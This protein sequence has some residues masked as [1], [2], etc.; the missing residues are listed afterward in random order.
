[1]SHLQKLAER[2]KY[3]ARSTRQRLQIDLS[4]TGRR[5]GRCQLERGMSVRLTR[6]ELFSVACLRFRIATGHL[7]STLTQERLHS[8]SLTTTKVAS[9]Y[10]PTF[11]QSPRHRPPYASPALKATYCI[12]TSTTISLYLSSLIQGR[13]PGVCAHGSCG[14]A[15]K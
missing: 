11:W 14:I 15:E 2:T 3:F 8:M 5:A 10:R 12:P 9:D 7:S 13:S 6:H 4:L 1:M